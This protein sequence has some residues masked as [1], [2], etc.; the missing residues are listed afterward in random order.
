MTL[1]RNSRFGPANVALASIG[2][3]PEFAIDLLRDTLLALTRICTTGV[4]TR[5]DAAILSA[6]DEV[7][8][9][10]DAT[11][12]ERIDFLQELPNE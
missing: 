6:W 8:Q 3:D 5:G 7:W 12:T 11:D 2:V 10:F 1:G 9:C 4:L